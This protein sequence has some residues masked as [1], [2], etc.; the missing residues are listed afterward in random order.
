MGRSPNDG[1]HVSPDDP[2]ENGDYLFVTTVFGYPVTC[3]VTVSGV[4]DA[5]KQY[6]VTVSGGDGATGGGTYEEGAPVTVSAGTQEG[7]TFRNWTAEGISLSDAAQPTISFTM[8]GNDVTLTANFERDNTIRIAAATLEP[9]TYDGST[10]ATV[11]SVDFSGLVNGEH[12]NIGTDYTAKAAF[13]SADAGAG[14]TATVTVTLLTNNYTFADGAKTA[15]YTLSGQSIAKADY[16]GTKSLTGH[17][18]SNTSG[19]VELPQPPDG[20]TFGNPVYSVGSNTI[21][22]MEITGNTLSY[23]GGSGIV[24]DTEYNV[25]I[26]VN[27]GGNYNDYE[28]TVTL[29]GTDKEIVEITGVAAA[30]GLVYNGQ[31][32]LGYTGTPSAGS[33]SG[34]FVITYS[35]GAAPTNAG[36]YTVTCSIPE[37]N[38][39]YAG[40]ITLNFTI[41]KATVTVSAPSKSIYVGDEIPELSGLNCNITGLVEHDALEGV[42]LAYAGTPNSSQTGSYAIVPSGG[43]FAVGNADNYIVQYQNGTLTIQDNPAPTYVVTVNGGTGGGYYKAGDTVSISATVPAG[44]AFA[45][46]SGDGVTFTDPSAINTTFTMPARAVTITANFKSSSTGGS[47]G[48]GNSSSSSNGSTTTTVTKPDGSTIET[49]KWPDGAQKIVKTNKNGTVTTTTTD[50]D[51]NRTQVVENPD[52]S[53]KTT[54][55]NKDGSG[56][57]TVVDERDKVVSEITLSQSAVEAA[58]EKGGTVGLPMPELPVTTDRETAPTVTVGL[59][60]NSS[61]KVEIPVKDVTPGTVAIIVKADGTEEVIKSSRTTENGVAVALS[62]GDTVKIVDNSKTFTDVPA[63]YWGADAVTFVASRELFG[64]T[65]ATTFSPDVAMTRGMIVTVLARL[66]SV[67]TDAGSTW[68]EAGRQWAMGNGISDGTNMDRGL[69]REQLATIL[70]RYA[71]SPSAAGDMDSY[72]DAGMVSD[73]AAPAMIWAVESGILTGTSATT[74][75]P[76]DPA[77]RAQVATILMRFCENM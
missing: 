19:E 34:D 22:R 2:L 14:K 21:V 10:A 8:P 58:Q 28:L 25:T 64:G 24:K 77:T 52:G 48:G 50:K 69:T 43:S 47:T 40:A 6:T 23:E 38:A 36:D 5:P 63:G 44:M 3:T 7:Y 12:L 67:D 57:V 45:G 32:Q 11:T 74:L 1:N 29:T 59:P 70:W 56:S 39:D 68:Y 72:T 41:E 60:T 37:D 73:W 54:I 65:G 30:T 20:A 66:E 17:I 75:S 9:K 61:V 53:S 13:D 27:G 4:P 51:G 55:D 15:A 62:D 46:W 33:Y 49:T 16:D 42:T 35:S 18:W 71:G 76:Q 31:K 26:P